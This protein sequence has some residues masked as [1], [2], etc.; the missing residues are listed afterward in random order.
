LIDD[1][2]AQAILLGGTDLALVFDQEKSTFPVI[3]CAVI[4]A[5]QIA[6]L[7]MRGHVS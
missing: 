5:Q 6:Q 7:A 2:G 3:D 1:A 4:H